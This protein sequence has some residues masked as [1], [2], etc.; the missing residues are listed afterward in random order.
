MLRLIEGLNI[1]SKKVEEEEV[2]EEWMES[3]VSAR[4]DEELDRFP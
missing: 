4:R 1:D 3:C 2:L